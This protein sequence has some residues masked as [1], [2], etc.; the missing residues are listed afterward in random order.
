MSQTAASADETSHWGMF[1]LGL[2][3][4]LLA[5]AAILTGRPSLIG[6]SIGVLA[7]LILLAPLRRGRAWAW[8]AFTATLAGLYRLSHSGIATLPLLIPPVVLN[9]F[10]AWVFGHTLV[11]GRMP[12]IERIARVMRDPDT[13]LPT[14]VVRY[15]RRVTLAWTVLFVALAVVNLVL[16]LCATPQGLLLAAGWRPPVT[17]PLA[18]WSL[19]ANVLNYLFVGALFV[20]EY[21]W[22]QRRLPQQGYRNFFDFTQRIIRLGTLF[23]PT[24]AGSSG[25]N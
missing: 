4:P 11:R 12:L 5:H 17:V 21:A 19:F 24:G 3:Y 18:L 25:E 9:A 23:R 8:L 1:S 15:T 10:M 13:P 7:A 14:E 2:C 16:A 20:L 22:R 6:L